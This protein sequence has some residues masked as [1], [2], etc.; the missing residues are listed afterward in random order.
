M[1][2]VYIDY[3]GPV[4]LSAQD[5]KHLELMREMHRKMKVMPE[6]EKPAMAHKIKLSCEAHCITIMKEWLPGMTSIDLHQSWKEVNKRL[7]GAK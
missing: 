3:L 6:S 7:R 5:I 1:N 4:F 2:I